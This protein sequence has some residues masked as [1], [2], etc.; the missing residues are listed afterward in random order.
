M[1][2]IPQQLDASEHSQFVPQEIDE[3][4]DEQVDESRSNEH[5]NSVNELSDYNQET[6]VEE[7]PIKQKSHEGEGEKELKP[8]PFTKENLENRNTKVTHK[9][10]VET[11]ES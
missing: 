1:K 4:N 8:R 2:V 5:Q 3:Q 6:Y 10:E 9:V 11:L 7:V